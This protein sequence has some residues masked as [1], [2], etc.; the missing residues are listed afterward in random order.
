MASARANSPTKKSLGGEVS[1]DDAEEQRAWI[2]ADRSRKALPASEDSQPD[3]SEWAKAAAASTAAH[4]KS[5][6]IKRKH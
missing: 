6:L 1:R 3:V 5:G 4:G 2:E